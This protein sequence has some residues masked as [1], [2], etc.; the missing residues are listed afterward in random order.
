MKSNLEPG[1]ESTIPFSVLTNGPG[2]EYTITAR[3]DRDFKITH[4]ER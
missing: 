3:N 2:G 4:P 1:I